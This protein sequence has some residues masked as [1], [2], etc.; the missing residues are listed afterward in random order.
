MKHKLK[1]SV[2][3]KPQ[4]SGIVSCKSYDVRE[5][6][7]R[8]LFGDKRRVTVL[9]PGDGVDEI[10]V[11]SQTKGGSKDGEEIPF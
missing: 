9:I 11:V 7:L 2:S 1:I 3:E 5:R 4:S 6:L 10:S 8:K